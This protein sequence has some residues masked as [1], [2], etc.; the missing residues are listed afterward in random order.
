MK[1]TFNTTEETYQYCLDV[2]DCLQT[3]C[4]KTREEAHQLLENF[5]AGDLTFDNN[6][7]RLHECPYY[8]AMG[9]A[10]HQTLGDNYLDWIRDSSIWPP[11]QDYRERYYGSLSF[12]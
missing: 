2:V 10:H 7:V 11:P 6:D 12:C 3:Y 1:F 5:W 4:N 8:W 9:I